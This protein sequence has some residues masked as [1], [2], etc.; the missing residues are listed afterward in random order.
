M[1][2]G[3]GGGEALWGLR[4]CQRLCSEQ[5][6]Q[7]QCLRTG[8]GG[9]G[10]EEGAGES[11]PRQ[12]QETEQLGGGG[13]AGGI[14]LGAAGEHPK[15]LEQG[16]DMCQGINPTESSAQ[17]G[18]CGVDQ[19]EQGSGPGR[20]ALLERDRGL[21]LVGAPPS[22]PLSPPQFPSQLSQQPLVLLD[23]LQ[24]SGQ[25]SADQPCPLLPGT[26]LFA[27]GQA[28]RRKGKCKM[29]PSS[30]AEHLVCHPFK[31]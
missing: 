20:V 4:G 30:Q 26:F 3:D 8:L 29:K 12:R 19:K 28:R 10:S 18:A 25:N 15:G 27:T 22:P 21:G 17:G 11:R 24:R 13:A 6:S 9:Q 23:L 31:N 14:G 16:A 1:R 2:P 7:S 5:A